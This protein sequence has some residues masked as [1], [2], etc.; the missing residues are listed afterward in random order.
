MTRRATSGFARL[1]HE[2]DRVA[3]A[4]PVFD[5]PAVVAAPFKCVADSCR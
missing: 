4:I 3:A 1:G 5:F 2:S